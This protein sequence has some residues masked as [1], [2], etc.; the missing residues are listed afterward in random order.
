MSPLPESDRAV[1]PV[2]GAI[3]IMTIT[4]IIAIIVLLMC[5]GFHLPRGE[6]QVPVIFKIAAVTFVPDSSGKNVRAFVTVTNIRPENYRNRYLKVITYVNGRNANINI[7][8]LNNDLICNSNHAGLYHLWGL[9]THGDIDSSLAI[10]P[11]KSDISLEYGKGVIR[12]GDT[13]TL[14]VIDTRTNQII[15]RDTYPAP[16]KYTTQWFYNHFLNPQAA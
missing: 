16:E 3:V 6:D 13:I 9:G 8:T 14:E 10:W 12:Q 1:S 4:I 7:P 2:I 15:S 11:G 5:L